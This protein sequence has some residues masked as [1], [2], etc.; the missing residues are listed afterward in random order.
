MSKML[1]ILVFIA[2]IILILWLLGLI[3]SFIGGPILWVLLVIGLILLIVW[4]TR[5]VRTKK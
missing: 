2:V 3:F 1:N 4:L 5:R